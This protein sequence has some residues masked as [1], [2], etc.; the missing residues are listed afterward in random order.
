MQ[1]TCIPQV[2]IMWPASITQ[3]A[4]CWH[5]AC[6][7]QWLPLLLLH[8]GKRAGVHVLPTQPIWQ[9]DRIPQMGF[10]VRALLAQPMQQTAE[11]YMALAGVLDRH[12]T[13][14][15][16]AVGHPGGAAPTACG[17]WGLKAT[18]WCHV[19]CSAAPRSDS[20]DLQVNLEPQVRKN[21]TAHSYLV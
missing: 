7:L 20:L 5:V 11:D 16:H 13:S 18:C 4:S 6:G 3:H 21:R 19:Q 17:P 14:V 10:G 15:A 2:A 9:R 1:A 8:S 12:V